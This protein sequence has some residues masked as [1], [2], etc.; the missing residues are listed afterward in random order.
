MR[1]LTKFFVLLIV[2]T[3]LTSLV[4]AQ[5]TEAASKSDG[6]A[7]GNGAPA[8]ASKEEVN[9][10][11]GELAAQRKTI[12]ELKALVEKLAAAKST[13]PMTAATENRAPGIRPV[14]NAAT[15]TESTQAVSSTGDGTVRLMNTVY[16]NPA[17]MAAMVDPAPAVPAKK[18]AQ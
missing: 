14:S 8:S 10:L 1:S 16:L 4:L 5:D 11:R 6:S 17:T 7:T 2:F 3:A 12:E 13:E 15:E 9:Q 18:E